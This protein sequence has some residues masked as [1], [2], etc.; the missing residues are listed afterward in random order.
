MSA[1]EQYAHWVLSPSN[2]VRTGQYIKLA[3]KRFL[4][5]LE[6]EDIYFDEDEAN[7][8]VNFIERY[9]LQWEGAWKGQ[10]F[11]LELWQKFALQNI[12][13]WIRKKTGKRRFTKAYI[14]ISKKNGKSSLSAGISL[15]HLLADKRINTP[16]VF[17][18]A[19]NEDQAKICVN[20]AGRI[21]EESPEIQEVLEVRL[22]RYKENITEVLVEDPDRGSGFIKALSKEGGDKTAKT[23]GGKHGINASLG[24]VDEFGMSPD[25]GASKTIDS[26]MVSRPERLMLY[27]T[28]AGYNLDGPCYRELRESGIKVLE[29]TIEMDSY[30]MMLF[31]IDKPIVDDK[32]QEITVGWLLEHEDHWQQCNPNIDVSVQRDALQDALKEAQQYGGTTEVECLT[33]NF[34]LWVNSADAFIPA[35]IWDK[36]THGLEIEL[37][38]DCYGGLEVGPS[39]EITALALLFPGEIVKI[40]MLWIIAEEALKNNDFYRDNRKLINVDPGNEVENSVAVEWILEEFQKYNMH[41]FC[42]PQPHKSNSIVQELIKSGYQGNPISQGMNG[43]SNATVEW[44]KALRAGQVEHFGDPI[45]KYHNSN[46]LAVRKEQGTRIE[47]N[48]KVLGVYACL[49]AWSQWLTI[50]ANGGSEI[51]ILYI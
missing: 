19:N 33:L 30:F 8:C 45:L 25:H 6:R 7:R 41:S 43:I 4:S 51:G 26:S 10:P 22:M 16:K 2:A 13:G 44:E 20:I 27:I 5:D 1:A 40:K 49:N 24:V 12:Y 29:G 23:S 28:T 21:V 47:K 15:F 9:C 11:T 3:A 38:S 50:Q 31:E 35:D 39:G 14:Q 17:T 18:A 36:N 34:N 37:G 42:F 32:P 48:G 46:C